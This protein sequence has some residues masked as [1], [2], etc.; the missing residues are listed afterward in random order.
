MAVAG[1]LKARERYR[2]RNV[3]IVLCGANVSLETLRRVLGS[4]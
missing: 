2:G 3:V 4:G 1:Y